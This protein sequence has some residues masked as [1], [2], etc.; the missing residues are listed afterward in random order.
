MK[1][2][3]GNGD[4]MVTNMD[5]ETYRAVVISLRNIPISFDTWQTVVI[6]VW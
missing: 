5:D 6:V 1:K 3:F 2:V 4:N